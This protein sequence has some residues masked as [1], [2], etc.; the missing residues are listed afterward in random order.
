MFRSFFFHNGSRE[1]LYDIDNVHKNVDQKYRKYSNDKNNKS[2][3]SHVMEAVMQNIK[4]ALYGR[5]HL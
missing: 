2:E 5:D 1:Q 3:N 4:G